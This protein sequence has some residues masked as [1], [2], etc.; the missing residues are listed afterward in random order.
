[1]EIKQSENEKEKKNVTN[2][3]TKSLPTGKFEFLRQK[4][5]RVCTLKIKEKS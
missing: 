1:M 2:L 3:F 5:G 4:L